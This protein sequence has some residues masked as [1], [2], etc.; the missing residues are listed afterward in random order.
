LVVL[1]A[2]AEGCAIITTPVGA[3]PEIMSDNKVLW[4]RIGNSDDIRTAIRK[5][6]EDVEL[7]IQ[8]QQEN[9]ELSK[10]YTVERHIRELCCI[11]D[12]IQKEGQN[13]T[14]YT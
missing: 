7:L 10:R 14:C 8:M 1:E 9:R 11:Y 6:A 5:L 12:G 3:T 2:M 4:V 13:E